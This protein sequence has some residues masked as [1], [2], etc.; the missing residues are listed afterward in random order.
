MPGRTK[1]KWWKKHAKSIK[2]R[3]K[4]KVKLLFSFYQIVTKVPE[5][6]LVTYPSSVESTLN[7]LSFTNL[8]LD[9][10]GLPLAC[11]SLG[12]FEAK[13][14]FLMIAPFGIVLLFGLVVWFRRWLA[15]RRNAAEVKRRS[16]ARESGVVDSDFV[17][18]VI[19]S[20][21]LELLQS[22]RARAVAGGR[23]REGL[24]PLL[25]ARHVEHAPEEVVR[26]GEPARSPRYLRDLQL[27]DLLCHPAHHPARRSAVARQPRANR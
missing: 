11:V 12:T 26:R 27:R 10:L 6:Y 19:G 20:D 3:L 7:T 9:G 15:R 16:D 14:I 24:Q 1:K 18:T 4:I 8:E 17:S 2:R 22:V 21:E 5:T 13:L 25:R 23:D